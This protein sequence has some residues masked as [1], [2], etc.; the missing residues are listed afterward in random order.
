M[1]LIRSLD[2]LPKTLTH[3]A[4]TIGNFD[5]VHRGHA[6]LIRRLVAEANAV[7]GPAIVFTFDPP[8]ARLLRPQ[9]APP[10]LTWTERKAELLEEM[11]V[12]ATIAYPTDLALLDL[13]PQ[14]F[15]RKIVVDGLSAKALV[16]GPNFCF[17]R[18]RSGNIETLASL[19]R[20]WQVTLHVVP[21]VVIGG[22][23]VSSSRVRQAL[24][25]GEIG[26]ANDLL[27]RPYRLRGTV[28]AGA[29]R[30]ATL[31]F[32][33]ANLEQIDTLIPGPGVYAGWAWHA[34]GV[35]PAAVHIGPNPTFGEH[36]RKVEV[37]LIDFAG[38]LYGKSLQ[39]DLVARLRDVRPFSSVE[40]LRG[41][42][43]RDVA[44]ARQIAQRAPV[45]RSG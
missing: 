2:S 19:C 44:A 40:A 1:P 18:G 7:G 36:A 33:T 43:A 37:H 6:Q 31:G 4:V 27:G 8:P 30:G 23:I 42:L 21:P 15:F 39:V 22:Q 38:H 20:E 25:A 5:G 35:W 10:P 14:A 41:Q 12:A 34:T 17:G 13:T 26:L 32:P 24:E 45:P 16:E 3:G 29:R 9:E 11:G 28:V